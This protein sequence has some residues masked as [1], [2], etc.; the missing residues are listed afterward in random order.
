MGEQD[1]VRGEQ[2]QSRMLAYRQFA[3]E[4]GKRPKIEI[5]AQNATQ[6]ALSVLDRGSAGDPWHS[7][8]VEHVGWDPHQS[9]CLHGLTVER[10]GAWVVAAVVFLAEQLPR[11]VGQDIVLEQ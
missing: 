4:I 10:P 1:F 9:A 6:L 7:L 8:V 11:T 5:N 3:D 2:E